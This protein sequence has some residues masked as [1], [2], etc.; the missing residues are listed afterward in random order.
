MKV[1]DI[2]EFENKLIKFKAKRINLEQDYEYYVHI[3]LNG[4]RC[5][6]SK[7]DKSIEKLFNKTIKSSDNYLSYV[8]D[9]NNRPSD[10]VKMRINCFYRVLI[11]V[12]VNSNT[13]IDYCVFFQ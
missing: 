1:T 13:I 4:K 8:I 5:H 9:I 10:F 2:N 12:K 11:I 3:N 6:L 7:E